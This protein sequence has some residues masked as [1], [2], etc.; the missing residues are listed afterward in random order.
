MKRILKRVKFSRKE[1]IKVVC[2][3]WAI[4]LIISYL[5]FNN[6]F[7]SICFSPYIIYYINKSWDLYEKR[8]KAEFKIQFFEISTSA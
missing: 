6:I 1:Y 3:G 4:L 2:K 7:L 5:F 8:K